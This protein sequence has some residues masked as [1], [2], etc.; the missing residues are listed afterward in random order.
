MV[1]KVFQEETPLC[2]VIYFVAPQKKTHD[3]NILK[4]T[5]LLLDC[6]KNEYIFTMLEQQFCL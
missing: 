2:R 6:T 3:E 1:L 5:S 4:L